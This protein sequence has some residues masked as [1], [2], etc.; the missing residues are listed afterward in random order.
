MLLLNLG[1]QPNVT[2]EKGQS[3]FNVCMKTKSLIVLF[4]KNVFAK[5]LI[6]SPLLFQAEYIILTTLPMQANGSGQQAEMVMASQIR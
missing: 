5:S 4:L 3:R 6:V 1:K 2:Q